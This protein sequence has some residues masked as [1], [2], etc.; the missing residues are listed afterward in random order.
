MKPKVMLF[1]EPTSALDPEMINEVLDVMV[2]LAQD[3]MTMVV[4]THEMGFARKAADRVVFMA[5]GQIV[6][7]AAPRSSSRPP[8][9]IGRRTSSPSSSRTDD[10]RALHRRGTE[11][12]I[13]NQEDHMRR[14]P[15]SPALRRHRDRRTRP[16]GVQQ[17]HAGRGAR[18]DRRAAR[19]DPWTVATDVTIDGSP[20]F[21]KIKSAAPSPS[22]SRRTSPVWATWTR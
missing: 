14:R 5:D 13:R 2:G 16:H 11:R 10:V 18:S 20:T 17:W 1:D 6:E 22:A 3:G 4:V 21:D 19:P 7:E 12:W 15:E 9:A 8:R